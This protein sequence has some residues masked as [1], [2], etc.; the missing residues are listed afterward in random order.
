M[1]RSGNGAGAKAG[2]TRFWYEAQLWVAV[3]AVAGSTGAAG[4]Q[5]VPV[6]LQWIRLEVV[7]AVA[8]ADGGDAG[9]VDVADDVHEHRLRCS[10]RAR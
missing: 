1:R 10:W 9:R 5:G 3:S 8:F 7:D 2:A 4:G 6:G